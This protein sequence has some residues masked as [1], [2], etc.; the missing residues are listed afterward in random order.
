MSI[1]KGIVKTKYLT[2]IRTSAI[3]FID[4]GFIK[5]YK[6]L[7]VQLLK[8][9]ILRLINYKRAPNIIYII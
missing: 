4:L 5:I 3:V 7:I 2:D 1:I 8:L 6:I 9:L